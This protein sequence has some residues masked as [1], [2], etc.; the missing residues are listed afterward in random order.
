MSGTVPTVAVDAL[1]RIFRGRSGLRRIAWENAAVREVTFAIDAGESLAL[2]GESGSG[3]T[4]IA[5]MLVGLES[6]TS[7]RMWLGGHELTG[8]PGRET[9]RLRAASI[10]VVFQDPYTSLTPH[11]SVRSALDEVQ[12]VFFSRSP[13]ERQARTSALLEAVGLDQREGA[14]LPRRL[15]GGQRQRAAIARALAVEP[16][17]LI[18]DEPVSALDVSIQAQILN[19]LADLRRSLDLTYLFITH[20][21]AVVRQVA[22]RVVVLYRGRVVELGRVEVILGHPLHPYTQRLLESVPRLHAIPQRR[23][24]VIG[25]LATGCVFRARCPLAQA[26]CEQEP[27]LAEVGPGHSCRCWLVAAVE[28]AAR[29]DLPT[30]VGGESCLPRAVPPPSGHGGT[31]GP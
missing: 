16:R 21:L 7:G 2:V 6:P 8:R 1:T 20:D 13:A 17:V 3:K 24:A 18:L 12:G 26:I 19:L 15:S 5:R 23:A 22:D 31:T 25:E 14:A 9:R 4:T 27:G 30:D 28:G 11:Q 10:Q 29:T